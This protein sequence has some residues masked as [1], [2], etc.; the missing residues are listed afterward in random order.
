MKRTGVILFLLSMVFLWTGCA[1]TK[2][3]VVYDQKD[4]IA[5]VSVVSNGDIN[6]IDEEPIDPK[7]GGFFTDKFAK[8]DPD[9]V[10]VTS[11]AKLIN[12]AE[13]IFLNAAAESPLVNLAEKGTVLNSRSYRDARINQYQAKREYVISGGYRFVDFRDKEFP[14]ALAEETGIQRCMFV[15]FDF[16][17]AM[18]SGFGKQGSCRAEVTMKIIVN[19]AKGKTVYRNSTSFWSRDTIKVSGGTYSQSELLA[20]FEPVISIL[21]SEFFGRR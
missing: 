6:W 21:C 7:S 1:S 2:S 14:S 15:E 11:A 16:T 13:T 4:P 3:S 17:K 9:V 8:G 12:T 19:D 20:L 10:F 18:V 5:L